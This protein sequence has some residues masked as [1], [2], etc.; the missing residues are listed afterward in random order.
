M[1]RTFLV[2]FVGV[3]AFATTT[4]AGV[5][6]RFMRSPDIRGDSI[7][8]SYEGDLWSVAAGGGAARRLTSHP[9]SEDFAKISPD[10]RLIAFTGGYDGSPSLYVIPIDGGAPQRVTWFGAGV[11]AVNWTTDGRKIIFRSGHENTFRP[12]VKLYTVTPEGSFP[13]Q[14]PVDRGTLC[15][16]SPDGTKMVY[17]RRG[18]EEYYWKRYKGG[19]YTEIWLCD[20]KANQ[21]TPL[22]D[23][24][25]KNAYPMWIGGRMYFVS[26]RGRNGISNLYAYDFATKKVDQVTKYDDFDVQMPSTD[27]KRIVYT[28]AGYLH[29]LDAAGDADRKVAVDIPTD[30]W[31]IAERT[32]NPRDYIQSMS[33]SNDGR[34]AVFE[35]RGDVFLVP[36]DETR[37][38]RNLTTTAG[39]RERFPQL[40][41]DGKRVAF[42]SDKTGEYQLYMMDANGDA[43]WEPLTTSLD[44]AVYHLEWSPDGTKILFGDKDFSIH[45]LDVQTKKLV[46][47]ASSNQLKND[48]FYW[49][50]SDYSWSPDSR[51]ITYSLV[52]F[53]RNSRV[54]LYSLDQDKS[55]PVTDGFYDSLNPS[56]DATGEYL[57]FLSYRDFT[58]R[59]DVFEDDH[60]IANPVQVMVVQLKA[61][62]RP[63]FDQ[64]QEGSKKGEAEPFRI[65]LAGIE[66]RVFPLPVPSGNYFYLKA[67]RGIVTWAAVPG[68]AE[69]EMEEIFTPSGAD[70]W[71]LHLFDMSAQREVGIEGTIS[72]WK[73][74]ANRQ[75]MI[76]KTGNVYQVN[77]VDKVLASKALGPRL[78]LDRLAYRVKPIEEWT[79]IFD[80]AWRWYR[81]FFYDANM[82]GRNW[83]KMGETYRAW[84]KDLSSRADLNW[85]LSQMVGELSVSHTYIS[86][87]D[88][89]PQAVPPNP[90][91]TGLLGADLSADASGYY[92]FARIYGPTGFNRDLTG[93]LVRPDIDPKEGGFLIAIDG[94]E[95]KAP[96]NPYKYLQVVR[97]QK[98]KITVNAKPT[99]VGA[100]TFEVEPLRSESALRYNRWVTDNM[101]KVLAASNGDI[102]YMHITAM[103]TPNIGQ[104]DKFWRAF[105][106]KKGLIIDVRGNGGGWTEYFII[107]KLERKMVA[108]NNLR[109][110]VPF[111][112]PGS[113]TTAHIVALT[114]EFNGSDGEAFLEDFK[115]NKLGTIIGVPSWGGLVGILNRQRTIDG[116][117]VEQSNNAFYG[118][119]G[120]W[121]VEN[122][123]VDPDILVDNDPASASAGKDLQ[124]EKALEVLAKQI[125]E[126]PFTF[127][128]RPAIPI[129]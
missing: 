72:D 69:A 14:L 33:V 67:G 118:R 34:T 42:F 127:P 32:I 68:I 112:Y 19:Q 110:I 103:S 15:S 107:D 82:H 116:G 105:R 113:T 16:F 28:Q 57:Y 124:L 54:F 47:V 88:F 24:V 10:G 84:V 7:V 55:F 100:R 114:N 61:G 85:L 9:G 66:E 25:G 62:Q 20:L 83:K 125:K 91:Y 111:R 21:F 128:P 13:E 79:Q 78:N 52:E 81:D 27:G 123:G 29:V 44:R 45:Y 120:K 87:G 26:D 38:P 56:F 75:Q 46:K 77:A 98:V 11:Q 71:S 18:N 90:A 89:G 104:F 41:P 53:N 8:F 51:W 119:E 63:P 49:E 31:Q 115:A 92:R 3:L 97:G 48:E 95:V 37:P 43:L 12:I 80:D 17:N 73:L 35:A 101:E 86:G 65:D 106:Y 96:D 76:V 94:H 102:G 39:T 122:H 36:T 50:V 59:I 70:K 74:S 40:S 109:N 58:T 5:P 23:Y 1:R 93:P 129:K 121:W 99:S 6:G 108:Y 22:T 117:A 64:P 2:L 60:V 30:R 126:Q 4:F